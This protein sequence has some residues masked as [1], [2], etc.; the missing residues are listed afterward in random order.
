MTLATE[1]P[2][3]Y[4]KHTVTVLRDQGFDVSE[5]LSGCGINER[6]LAEDRLH[7]SKKQYSQ[8][9]DLVMHDLHVPG[10]GLLDGQNMNLLDH[11]ILGYAMYASATVREAIE[12]HT[13]YQDIIGAVLH[14]QLVVEADQAQLR[15]IEIARPDLTN[16]EE[17]L[18]YH[19]EQ[20]FCL[21]NQ[22]GPAF[23]NNPHWLTRVDFSYSKPSY[24]QMYED[25][26]KCP[27]FFD[28]PHQKIAFDV[29]VLDQ[30]LSFANEDAAKLCDKQCSALLQDIK[31]K[32]G[33]VGE[34]RRL[35]GRQPG[36]LLTIEEA[37][38]E[39]AMSGRT[40]RRRLSEEGVTY[41]QLVLDFRMEIATGC[42]SNPSMSITDVAYTCGYNEYTS[43]YRAF[44]HY[45]G[46]TPKQY[47]D[48]KSL[49][50]QK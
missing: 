30:R 48:K 5:I 6:A 11:G 26:F 12:R 10:L 2:L 19:T 44:A 39:M 40:L 16:S 8:F 31:A 3:I 33:V 22:H 24:S 4:V 25:Y 1:E 45:F 38:S 35:L 28:Q 18:R 46:V 43:F 7:I 20:L 32:D 21:W 27:I 17:K 37:G 29:A 23:G 14:T 50:D 41:K 36:K 9:L 15:V 47:R 42:L 13:K 34:I 49:S